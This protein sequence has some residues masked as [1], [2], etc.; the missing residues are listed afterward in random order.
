MRSECTDSKRSC[1]LVSSQRLGSLGSKHRSF[2]DSK[3]SWLL[4]VDHM[5]PTPSTHLLPRFQFKPPPPTGRDTED[6]SNCMLSQQFVVLVASSLSLPP[7]KQK[8]MCLI[9]GGNTKICSAGL[10][11]FVPKM[12]KQ[13][14]S[15]VKI[16]T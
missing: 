16:K 13:N 9:P 2:L 6:N 1:S 5:I 10:Y 12:Y 8:V 14:A 3:R 4:F 7:Y 15:G 11:C